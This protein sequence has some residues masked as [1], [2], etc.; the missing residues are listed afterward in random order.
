[1]P[2]RIA[3]L[4][5]VL[6]LLAAAPGANAQTTLYKWIDED[7]KTQYSDKLPA[8]FKGEVTRIEIEKSTEPPPTPATAPA[9]PR[10]VDQKPPEDIAAKRRATRAVLEARLN[11]ARANVES[12]KKA[13]ADSETPDPDERQ[14]V[15]QR[16]MT[17]GMH[18]MAPRSNCRRET[19]KD[20]KQVL[21]CPTQVPR[22][23]YLERVAKLE[24]DLRKAEEEL[25]DAEQAWR[26]GVD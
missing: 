24:E 8:K 25:A 10:A 17:G 15:Q 1:L 26:R 2:R 16:G 14:T 12:A 19:G 13:L 20:G 23:E 21:M 6:A 9:P 4:A 3:E 22:P 11:Q 7:G 18:G 5:L